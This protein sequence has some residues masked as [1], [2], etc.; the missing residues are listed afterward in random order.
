M[1][2]LKFKPIP[3]TRYF[4]SLATLTSRP[5][6]NL[7]AWDASIDHVSGQLP[8]GESSHWGIPF[9]FGPA[10]LTKPGLIVLAG[11]DE[12]TIPLKTHATHVCLA[13]FC[14]V[15]PEMWANAGGGEPLG[16]Y[17]LHFDDGKNHVQSIR[18]RFEINPFTVAWGGDAFAAQRSAMP[19]PWDYTTAPAMA[20][21]Q[22]Q[23][24][25]T[26]AGGSACQF[27]VYALENPRPRKL[28][29]SITLR[30]VSPQPIAI[31]GMTLYSGPGH[32]LRHVPRKVYKLIIPESEKTVAADLKVQL[33]LGVITRIYAAPAV[34]DEAWVTAEDRGLGAPTKAEMATCEFLLEATGAEGATLTVKSPS[35][36]ERTLDFGKAYTRGQALSADRTTR[37]QLLH[38]RSTWVH[39]TVIDGSTGKETPTRVHIRGPHGEYLPPYGHHAIVNDRWFE[40]YAGDLQ[41]GSVSY[42]YV[43]G[44]FQVDLPVGE[45]Y[46]EVTKGFEYEPLRKKVN[47]RPGQRD[48]KLTIKRAEDWRKERWVTADTHV[49][50]ISPETAWLEGQGEGVNLINLLASQWGRLYTNVSDI[51]GTASGCSRDDTIVWVGTENRNHLLGHISML[52]THGDPVFPMC[53]GGPSEAYLGDPD[54]V[55][56]SEWAKTCK[57][58]DGVVVR[59]H[60]PFPVCEEPLYFINELLDGAELRRFANPESGSLDEFCFTE[61]YRYLNCGYRAAAVGGTDKMSAGMPVGGVRTYAQ[62]DPDAEF[63]FESWGQAVRCGRTFTTS[64]P[65][66]N[67][68]VEG[69]PIGSEIHMR[70]AG[71]TLEVQTQAT[72]RWPIHRLEIVVNGK[73]VAATTRSQGARKLTLTERLRIEGSCWIAARCGS[74]LMVSHCWPIH[75]GAHTSPVYIICNNERLFS[76]SDASYMLTLIDGGLT[77]LDTLS[78]RYDEKRHREMKAIFEHARQHLQERMH[79]HEHGHR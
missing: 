78:V 19:V 63:T 20:W 40:D 34:V 65:L 77:Y 21:G 4:N 28:I 44:R 27:W 56:L 70:Q 48:L 26:Y 58:R 5:T 29:R 7:P 18:R 3:L 76:P 17:T 69:Q 38:P 41:L 72:S 71:G 61:W 25:V 24:G 8:R 12:V 39:V 74:R 33:D 55:L 11:T 54:V 36:A 16:E 47:V 46:F 57:E 66:I 43:P 35:G 62:L 2:A 1:M 31:L 53:A 22:L 32:P 37:I 23:T 50:F 51:S 6:L 52:G 75:L 68:T 10:D 64:G 42:A 67:M 49:H 30:A 73:V 13:H 60:F 15:T 14:N 9:R 79:K 45:V 59:P